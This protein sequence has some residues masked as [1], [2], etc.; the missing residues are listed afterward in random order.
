MRGLLYVTMRTKIYKWM[1]LHKW[2][3][4]SGRKND[5]EIKNNQKMEFKITNKIGVKSITIK[6]NENMTDWK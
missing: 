1:K 3:E 6:N 2:Y 5:I 4:I